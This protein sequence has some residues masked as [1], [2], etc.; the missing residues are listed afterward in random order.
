MF[1]TTHALIGALVAEQM[2]THPYLAFFMGMV[3]H[4]LAD[5]I[6]HGDSNLYKGYISGSKSKMRKAVA[7]VMLDGIVALFFVLFLFNTKFVEHRYAIS[8]GIVGGVLPDLLVGLY[9]A[10]QIQGLRWFHRVHFFFHNLIS[11]RK[12]DIALH[13]GI[14]MQLVLLFVV[15]SQV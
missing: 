6:P 8:L 5:I 15:W 13:Y 7:Y 10:T 3:T 4:F 14:A 9:E 1:I 11:S 12:G 2:P